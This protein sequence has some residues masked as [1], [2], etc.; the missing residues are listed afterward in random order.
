MPAFGRILG[1]A[2]PAVLTISGC[3]SKHTG[4]PVATSSGR[5]VDSSWITALN[6]CWPDLTKQGYSADDIRRNLV[7]ADHF[8]GAFPVYAA[9][10]GRSLDDLLGKPLTIAPPPDTSKLFHSQTPVL[11]RGQAV[12]GTGPGMAVVQHT[13]GSAPPDSFCSIQTGIPQGFS[14]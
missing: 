7:I 13:E 12:E 5:N 3:S 6:A 8:S 4:A 1:V 11:T 14:K 2:L 10:T 9:E